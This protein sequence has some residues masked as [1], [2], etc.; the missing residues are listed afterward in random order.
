[1]VLAAILGVALLPASPAVAG[2]TD[3]SQALRDSITVDGLMRHA[4]ALQRISD[5]NGNTRASGTA[6][7]DRSAGYVRDVLTA[8]GLQVTEQQFAFTY[9]NEVS[10][11]L[12]AQVSPTA[13][14]YTAFTADYSPSG[15]VTGTIVPTN[16]IQV[17]PPPTPG[18]TSGCEAADFVAASPTQPQIALIQRGT[19]DYRAKAANAKAA[20]YDA[21]IIFNEGQPGRQNAVGGTLFEPAALPVTL[22]SY[23][24]GAQLYA[25][26]RAGTTVGRVRT[27]T[28]IRPA[29]TTN[30]IAETRSG[31]ANEVVV[32]GAHLDSVTRGPGVNDNGS[33]VAA[34]IETA[35]QAAKLGITLRQKIRFAFWGAEE[36]GGLGS[37]HYV[38]NLNDAQRAAISG[39]LNFDM[40]GSPNFVRFLYDG[41]GSDTGGE[42][43][44]AGS[45]A[46]ESAF[47]SYFRA[48]R[49]PVKKVSF[50]FRTDY[51]A[52]FDAGIPV[53][54]VHSGFDALKTAEEAAVF[55]G[56]AGV[57]YDPCYHK[58]CDNLGN[59][60]TTVLHQLA[61]GA[62]HAIVILAAAAPVGRSSSASR[63]S[64]TVRHEGTGSYGR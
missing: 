12:V 44:P 11:A 31:A 24:D 48:Q 51:V 35:A 30:V 56:T 7:Y 60:N 8:A 42:A 20:G 46:I 2:T 19:C 5:T 50:E 9:Y 58:A 6:G 17:P 29:T 39:Y 22:I 21:V 23:A 15:D 64:A 47:A 4:R 3:D 53:G 59:I 27:H 63:P 33:G 13:K 18:V 25:A 54:G 16:D 41:D 52:F 55:G 61:D 37:E 14:T 32:A 45:A 10:P 1:M 43:G 40:V 49:L 28:E 62:A 26:T 57:P 38:A 36:S 34:L